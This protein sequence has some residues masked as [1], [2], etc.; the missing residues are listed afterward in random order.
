[1]LAVVGNEALS[2]GIYFVMPR[3]RDVHPAQRIGTI[4]GSEVEYVP[5][6]VTYRLATLL[7]GK[8]AERSIAVVYDG[9][10][11]VDDHLLSNGIISH[12]RIS[13]D[14]A[15][16]APRYSRALFRLASS[17]AGS[18]SQMSTRATVDS[19]RRVPASWRSWA[20]CKNGRRTQIGF[21]RPCAAAL[22]RPIAR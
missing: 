7:V 11:D 19:S 22:F 5:A 17:P 15:A 20:S 16:S 6:A 21:A 8:P 13:P 2:C 9:L 1:M 10:L 12:A 4:A 18:A 14:S 3:P